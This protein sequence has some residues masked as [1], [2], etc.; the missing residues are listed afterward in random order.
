VYA[1]PR[2][3]EYPVIVNEGVILAGYQTLLVPTQIAPEFVQ[4]HLEV[5]Q[6]GQMNP[7]TVTYGSRAL[8][9]DYLAF[10]SMR[11]YIGWCEAAHIMLGTQF[12]SGYD[13]K[14]SGSHAKT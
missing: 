6:T 1:F 13:V 12:C 4:F 5:N 10:K 3:A 2:L 8:I 11:C 14:Y 7:F 9:I